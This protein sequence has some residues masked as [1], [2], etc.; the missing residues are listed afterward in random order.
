MGKQKH[1]LG[2]LEQSVRIHHRLVAIH[3][4][5]NGNGRHARLVADVVLFC[6][7]HRLPH[8]P[9]NKL[10]EETDIRKKYI[11]ALKAADKGSYQLLEKF[12]KGLIDKV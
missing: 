3:P 1:G 8:W 11:Q 4:F 5:V 6:H 12:T 9:N 7:S 10:I 2:L